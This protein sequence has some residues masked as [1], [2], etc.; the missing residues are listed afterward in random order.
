MIFTF[1]VRHSVDAVR[2]LDGCVVVGGV[3]TG[4]MMGLAELAHSCF[5][6]NGLANNLCLVYLEHIALFW[7]LYSHSFAF[8]VYS[9]GVS[10]T[11]VPLALVFMETDHVIHNFDGYALNLP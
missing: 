2:V 5:M 6:S 8:L 11:K 7:V 9:C 10:Q 3:N 4:C 1:T